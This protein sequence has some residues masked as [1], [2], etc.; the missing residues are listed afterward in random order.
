MWQNTSVSMFRLLPLFLILAMIVEE[1]D[2]LRAIT[3][4]VGGG[5][6][7]LQPGDVLVS[8]VASACQACLKTVWPLH[9]PPVPPVRRFFFKLF[10][11][12]LR[13]K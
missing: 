5:G 10:I 9:P 8:S 3:G 12:A 6:W 11:K 2:S 1:E 7:W 4:H 13:A